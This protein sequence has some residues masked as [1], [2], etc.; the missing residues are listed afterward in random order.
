M[1][2]VSQIFIY[3]IKSLG[4]ISMPAAVVTSRGLQYDRRWMLVDEQNKFLTQREHPQ[5]ALLKTAIE[6]EA[7]LIHQA[8][9][10]TDN[11]LLP[12]EPAPAETIRVNVWDDYCE[13]QPAADT[14]NKWFSKK[15]S[16][17]C[18]AVY[19][20][21]SSKR[22]LNPNYEMGPDGINSFSDDYPLLMI[23]QAS[24]NDLNS[25]LQ[26]AVPMNRFR[27]NLV[28]TGGLPYQEDSM[29]EFRVNS[30]Y[31]YGV[32]LC[33]RCIITCINQETTERE[34]EPLKTLATYR[35]IGNKVCF[36]QNVISGGGGRICV[37]D[38]IE[39]TL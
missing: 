19:M 26:D 29:K 10:V 28:F 39:V 32:K 13:A 21:E 36:G 6:N 2:Q 31:F 15:L 17:E 1:L 4:G 35:S 30:I 9:N 7:I 3:P 27:P 5:M 18:K 8:S 24:L 25:R 33:G 22:K 16:I 23:G 34:K 12:L 11:I 20:P 38:I 37:G 14:I